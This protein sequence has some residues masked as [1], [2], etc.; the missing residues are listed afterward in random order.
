[1]IY[2]VID[3][4][5][6]RDYNPLRAIRFSQT[7]NNLMDAL[8]YVNSK[9]NWYDLHIIAEKKKGEP[10]GNPSKRG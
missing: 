2:R 4:R 3:F 6:M 5:Y 9:S 1:M 7:F 10:E 8:F